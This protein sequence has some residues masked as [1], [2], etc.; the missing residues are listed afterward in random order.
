MSTDAVAHQ[1][2]RWDILGIGSA[3]V[4]DLLF[5]P[6]Y[7][8]PDTKNELL[9][10]ERH[11]GGLMATALV[12]AA[13]LGVRCGYAGVLGG[14]DVSQW[15]EAD[16]ARE[17]LDMSPVVHRQDSGSIH[18]FIMVEASTR[19]RTIL[20]TMNGYP[21]AD[22]TL[23]AAETI[24][25]A[26]VLLIDDVASD[27]VLR[28]V[29]IA[30]EAGI[31]VI[32]DFEFTRHPRLIELP[33]HLI[34]SA[35]YAA[36]LTGIADPAAAAQHLWHKRRDV[37]V[38]TCGAEGC[39]YAPGADAVVHQPAFEVEVVDTTGCGDVFHGAY[40]S[41]LTWGLPLAER[42]R[43]ASATAALKATQPGGR[44]GIPTRD[45]VEAFLRRTA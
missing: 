37:V 40:A 18:A 33:D 41:A 28:A 44:R 29:E 1:D 19:T 32:A 30:H 3:T 4:D 20:Y 26:R 31:P 16:L 36:G 42:I 39:W 24:R 8:V 6:A 38:I 17:G 10:S 43:F 5:L 27:A 34:V 9:H 22:E 7:P 12:A 15:I 23:P 21:G 11:G 14:D 25:A 13:R 45:Q 2:A 35:H